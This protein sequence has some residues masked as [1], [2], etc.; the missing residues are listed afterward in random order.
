[1][2]RAIT[3]TKRRRAIQ[4]AYNEAHGI[5]PKTIVKGVREV[6]EISSKER[7]TNSAKP[8]RMS[9]AERRTAHR[10]A[11]TGDEEGGARLLEFEHAA[12]LRDQIDRLRG[13]GA[14]DGTQEAPEQ[15][16]SKRQGEYICE[17]R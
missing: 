12:Y 15:P 11:D 3:E 1:M 2:E 16:L 13:A 4:M 7:R 5:V 6:L 17:Q 10:P 14:E 9:K 8:S